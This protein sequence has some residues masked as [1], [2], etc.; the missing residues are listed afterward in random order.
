MFHTTRHVFR[1]HN[2]FT[3]VDT[4]HTQTHRQTIE[5]NTSFRYGGCQKCA[6]KADQSIALL[7]IVIY[8]TDRSVRFYPVGTQVA[9]MCWCISTELQILAI[10]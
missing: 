1:V 10:G 5:N 2:H 7:I 8:V 6:A 9:Y 3:F 4:Q